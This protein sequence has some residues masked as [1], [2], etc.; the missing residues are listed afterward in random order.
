MPQLPTQLRAAPEID[1]GVIEALLD[2]I[3]KDP[4]LKTAV[5]GCPR[6]RADTKV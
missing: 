1:E 6:I 3:E 2:A 4:W 5:T